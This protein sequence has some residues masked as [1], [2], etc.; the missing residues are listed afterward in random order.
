MYA[1][2]SQ[3]GL[4]T[5]LIRLLQE[6]FS[7]ML[8]DIIRIL[9]TTTESMVNKMRHEI[10]LPSNDVTLRRLRTNK[11]NP[12]CRKTKRSM[13][14]IGVHAAAGTDEQQR[15]DVD[16]LWLRRTELFERGRSA[17][18]DVSDGSFKP[19]KPPSHKRCFR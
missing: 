6:I 17:D 13:A 12:R 2:L 14:F 3:V 16:S 19:G 11:R 8:P 4:K 15:A 1:I 10:G 7:A 9:T 5:A 18:G